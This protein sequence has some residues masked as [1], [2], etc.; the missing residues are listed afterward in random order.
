M[1]RIIQAPHIALSAAAANVA[2]AALDVRGYKNI[3][4]AVYTTGSTTAT[5]K[6]AVSNALTVPTFSSAASATNLY[7]Y[8]QITPVN[9]QLTAD[10]LAGSTGIALTGTDIVKMYTVDSSNNS[11]SFRWICPIVSGY[12]AG[13]IN[14]AITGS[15]DES[16]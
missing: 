12:S 14:V 9:S 2:G 6:F 4:L 3:T 16:R 1:S 7:D 5:I 15:S 13:S 10:H 8:V 11:C